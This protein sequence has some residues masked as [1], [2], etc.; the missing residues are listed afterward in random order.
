MIIQPA[1]SL[2][3]GEETLLNILS[4]FYN[5]DVLSEVQPKILLLDEST[6]GYH[7]IWQK[8]FVKSLIDLLPLIFR[9]RLEKFDDIEVVEVPKLQVV[10]ST[11]DPFCLSELPYYNIIYLDSENGNTKVIS[12]E[13][14]HNRKKAFGAN[15]TDLI[16]DSFFIGD[17]ENA[18]VGE[19]AQYKINKVIEWIDSQ[20]KHRNNIEKE[21][22]LNRD[23][24]EKQL[25]IV[26]L[27]D[28]HIIQLKLAEMLDEL[29]D[30]SQAQ[31]RILDNQIELLR[32]RRDKL[33]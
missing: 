31:R 7:P 20:N 25:K 2:S 1:Y 4:T 10:F 11:H 32:S 26:E 33:K 22:V 28:E 14:Y 27:I 19:F 18:L 15:I 21:Y 12:N 17:E 24:L 5:Q 3:Q 29:S 30:D 9:Y 13:D 16:E 8:K 23:E 6:I